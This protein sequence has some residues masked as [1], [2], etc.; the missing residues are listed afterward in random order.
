MA[1]FSISDIIIAV[2]LVVNA[3]ALISSKP[4][5]FSQQLISHE[6]DEEVVDEENI[7]CATN[8]AE[9]MSLLSQ[10]GQSASN[11]NKNN[12]NNP[13]QYEKSRDE[14]ADSTVA[15]VIVRLRML[16]SCVKI[17]SCVIVIWNFFFI[18]LMVF[19]F[20]SQS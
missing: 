16:M 11:K 15:S 17:Y 9:K 7:S 18:I 14:S 4:P 2:T 8:I 3:L 10:G 20:G 1:I 19:V 12:Q 5:R 6:N 13:N